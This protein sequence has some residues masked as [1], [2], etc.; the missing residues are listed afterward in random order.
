MEGTAHDKYNTP[1]LMQSLMPVIG[2]VINSD[3][4]N[5][6]ITNIMEGTTHQ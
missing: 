4:I 6:V 5:V 2:D 1:R 3:V